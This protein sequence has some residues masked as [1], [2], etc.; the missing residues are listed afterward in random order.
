MAVQ[1]KP[2]KRCLL[3]Q[4]AIYINGGKRPDLDEAYLAAPDENVVCPQ[5][6]IRD[7]RANRIA[8]QGNITD[9]VWRKLPSDTIS[10]FKPA[11]TSSRWLGRVPEPLEMDP[12]LWSADMVDIGHSKLIGHNRDVQRLYKIPPLDHNYVIDNCYHEDDPDKETSR[13]EYL[14][15]IDEPSCLETA[16]IFSNITVSTADLFRLWPPS[17]DGSV[18]EKS[19]GGRPREY[20]WDSFYEEIIVIADLDNLPEVQEELI[21]DM[22]DWFLKRGIDAPGKVPAHSEIKKRISRIYNHPRK[23]QP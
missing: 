14:A 9:Q 4:A 19:K 2:P 10:D 8:A 16:F 11:G 22:E 6:L 23:K 13:P 1:L 17:T 5:D 7:L 15:D 20:P 18:Q 21:G 12:V 3:V